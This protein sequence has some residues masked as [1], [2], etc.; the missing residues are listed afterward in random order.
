MNIIIYE[1]KNLDCLK[2]LTLNHSPLELRVGAFTNF[3]RIVKIF[4]PDDQF[5]IIVRKNIEDLIKSKFPRCNVNPNIVPEGLCLNSSAIF[6]ET[7]LDLIKKNQNLSSNKQLV[8]FHL[9]KK[10]A[11]ENFYDLVNDKSVITVESNIKVINNIWDIFKLPQEILDDDFK[12]FLFTNNY[13]WHHSLIKI[14]EERVYI[15]DNC[16]L[17]A[18]VILDASNGPIIIDNNTIIDHHVS[19]KGPVYIGKDGY[20]SAGSR[21]KENTIIGPVCKIG[22]EISHCNFLGY[23]NKVHDGFLGHSYIGEW[24][25]IGAGT[26]NSNLKN[27]YGN[28][29]ILIGKKEYDTKQQFLGTLIADYTRIA[30]GTTINTGSYFSIGSNIFNHEFNCKYMPAFSWGINERVVFNKFIDSISKM[31]S[32]RKEKIIPAEMNFLENLYN[33]I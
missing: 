10:I 7:N 1:D 29:R 4:N 28:I 17:K 19:I 2:P 23:S 24:V 16:S 27:N 18:G 30:I 12:N 13:N 15:G 8:S 5:I 25:N 22:G 20:I 11:S 31:K 21:I 6:L 26:N 33:D 14:N 9:K 3:E 32:R